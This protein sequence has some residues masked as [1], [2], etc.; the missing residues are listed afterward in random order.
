MIIEIPDDK[1]NEIVK[2]SISRIIDTAKMS[3]WANIQFRINGKDE[4]EEA[5]WIKYMEIKEK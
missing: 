1:I 4:F 3:H 5:D 2:E